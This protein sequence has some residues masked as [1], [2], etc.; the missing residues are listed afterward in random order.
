MRK[1][2]LLLIFS[3]LAVYSGYSQKIGDDARL[4]ASICEDM[5][6]RRTDCF[7]QVERNNGK[8]EYV[9]LYYTNQAILDLDFYSNVWRYLMMEKGVWSYTITQ[10][11][12][13][14]TEELAERYMSRLKKSKIGKYYFDEDYEYYTEIYLKDK[15]ATVKWSKVN[16]SNFSTEQKKLILKKKEEITQKKRI[17]KEEYLKSLKE[18]DFE[19]YKKLYPEEYERELF[20]IEVKKIDEDIEWKGNDIIGKKI[21]KLLKK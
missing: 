16:L 2:F 14:S 13:I 20:E 6:K 11:D 12:R 17:E 8:I 15:K 4:V 18:R 3:V 9:L 1:A 10:Y 5:A 21:Q 7:C 19:T